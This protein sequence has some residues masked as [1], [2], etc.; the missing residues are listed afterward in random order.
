[1][2][3]KINKNTLMEGGNPQKRYTQPHVIDYNNRSKA[4]VG[5]HFNF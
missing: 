4:V 3:K 2:K 1:M 5:H